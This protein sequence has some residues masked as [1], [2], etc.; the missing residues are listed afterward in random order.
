MINIGVIGA[1]FIANTFCNAVNK[2]EFDAKLYAIGSRSLERATDYQKTYGFEKAYGS[3]K[4]LYN[5]PNIN[6]IYIATPHG[7]HYEQMMEILDYDKH[8]LCEKSFTLNAQQA[9][10][11]FQKAR[12]KNVFIMEAVWTRFLPT[13]QAVQRE[14]KNQVI[15]DIIK[16]EAD[17]CFKA[18]KNSDHR[19]FNPSLGGGALLDVGIYPIT[20]ANLFMGIPESI[21]STVKK[22]NTGVDLTEEI[23]FSYP[24]G[25]AIL[26]ASLG[27]DRPLKG[28]I[29]GTKGHI[30]VDNFF[31][32]EHATIYDNHG[33]VL[34]EIE[35]PH[36]VNGFE[37]EIEETLSCIKNGVLESKVMP[38]QETLSILKQ[39][40]QIR[41]S[42]NF[43][44]PK[45]K[46]E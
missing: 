37:Y 34:K 35:F 22:H 1:G 4:E 7:L 27:E 21:T 14:I 13:I 40:D 42:W 41:K 17:F 19:L 44:Y 3:Y 16:V 46:E 43:Y 23:H 26:H 33:T 25:E 15:G 31:Y 45:E 36:K 12:E 2:S 10:T 32:T 38:Y 8:I 24:K 6:L 20:F 18:D 9:S 5:D 29:Y 39:M 11:V 30:V 28:I